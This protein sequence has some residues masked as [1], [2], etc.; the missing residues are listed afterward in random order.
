MKL[1]E[2]HRRM[3]R[4]WLRYRTLAHGHE[5][6]GRLDAAWANLEAAHVLSQ[7]STRL[8]LGSHLAMLRLAWRTR[9]AHETRGQLL[10][11]V[12]ACLLTW[13]WMPIGNSGRSNVSAL[14]AEPVPRD[15]M[16]QMH[17]PVTVCCR[18]NAE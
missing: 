17:D 13:A 18:L 12:A 15:I 3:L 14:T 9:D 11:L 5:R 2:R 7:R 4:A 6:A 10:R 16:E 8:H 1:T